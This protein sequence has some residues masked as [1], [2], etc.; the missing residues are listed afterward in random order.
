[1]EIVET[2][3]VD[4]ATED[5]NEFLV[6]HRE[7]IGRVAYGK[8]NK[9]G[10]TTPQDIEQS[11]YEH[12]LKE[13]KHYSG[14]P[15]S[16]VYSYFGKAADQYLAAESRDYMYFSGSF[17]YSSKDVRRHLDKSTWSLI[18]EA[19]DLEARVDLRR[20]FE[21]LTAGQKKAVFSRWGLRRPASEETVNER[22]AVQR[23]VDAMT[24]WLNRKE[25]ATSY[26]LD[27]IRGLLGIPESAFGGRDD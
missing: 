17:V 18:E 5:V 26:S 23:G 11:I 22:K 16:L 6:Y 19:P 15:T 2:E 8:W 25:K 13:W 14:K 12:V 4:F 24:H 9:Q 7:K 3:V 20:A 21:S 1:M 27:D 10:F